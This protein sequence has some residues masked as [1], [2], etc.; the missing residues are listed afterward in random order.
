MVSYIIHH[1]IFVFFLYFS[2]IT[3]RD[4]FTALILKFANDYLRSWPPKIHKLNILCTVNWS[5][6]Y[7]L[8]VSVPSPS[9]ACLRARP[10]PPCYA[11]M[12]LTIFWEKKN[13]LGLGLGWSGVSHKP[14]YHPGYRRFFPRVRREFLVAAELR[15]SPRGS[16]HDIKTWQNRK[17]PMKSLTPTQGY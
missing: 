3:L 11:R 15:R 2:P 13:G 4:Q 7:L 14:S 1:F 16:L 17:A 12:L 10:K 5:R 8:A 9:L 6:P